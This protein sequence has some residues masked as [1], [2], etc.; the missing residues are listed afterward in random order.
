MTEHEAVLGARRDRC[1]NKVNDIVKI[2]S[3]IGDT[4]WMVSSLAV[5]NRLAFTFPASKNQ[6]DAPTIPEYER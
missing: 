3:P 2:E 6:M 5:T 1:Q 4:F